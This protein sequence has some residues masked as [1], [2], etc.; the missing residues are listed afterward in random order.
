MG[1]NL[2][3]CF[4]RPSDALRRAIERLAAHGLE[5]VRQSRQFKTD[6]V[7]G[8]W[9]A[10]FYNAVVLVRTT[11]S[12]RELLRVAKAIEREAGRRPGRR[13]GPRPLDIDIIAYERRIV[14]ANRW[15]PMASPLIPALTIPHPRAHKRAFVLIPLQEIDPHWRHP[16]LGLTARQLLQRLPKA[17]RQSVRLAVPAAPAR[18][19]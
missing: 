19:R 10:D 3:G 7:G 15:Q 6:P 16:R 12:P 2:S 18:R 1:S 13:W 8:G 11:M 14:P 9:Q 4:G 17:V 5:V